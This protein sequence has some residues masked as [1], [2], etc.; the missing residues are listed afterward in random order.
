MFL[1]KNPH[2][3]DFLKMAAKGSVE[4]VGVIG[5]NHVDVDAVQVEI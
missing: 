2:K 3:S 4:R 5:S 1:K